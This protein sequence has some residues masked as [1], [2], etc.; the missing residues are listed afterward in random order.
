MSALDEYEQLERD[1]KTPKRLVDHSLA[2]SKLS[3]IGDVNGAASER[4]EAFCREKQITIGALAELG[5]R[6][7]IDSHGGVELAWGYEHRGAITAVK[8]RLVGDRRSVRTLA[9]ST[10]LQ[11]LVIGDRS[12]LDWFVGEGETDSCR[13]FELVGDVAAILC[14]PSGAL[15]FKREWAEAIPRGATVHLCH[16]ADTKGDQGAAKAAG[17][18]GGKTVRVRP[19]ADGLDWCS[20]TGGQAEF[21]ALVQA[22]R[23]VQADTSKLLLDWQRLSE[24]EMRSIVFRE[25]P[26]L[27][28]DAFHL[29][30]G[31]KGTG[32]GTVLAEIASRVTRGELGPNR[33]VVWIGSEDSAAIDI[34]PRIVAAGGDPE[35][36]L[37][38]KHGWIQLPRDIDEIT[39]AAAELGDVGMI[40]IDPVGNHIAGKNSNAET[41]IRD[42]ISRLNQIADEQQTMV[43]G[44]RHL[45]EKEC[46]RGVLAAILGSSAWVQTPRAVL[47]VVRDDEDTQISHVQCVAGNRLPAGTAGR[48]FRIDGVLLPGLENEV[49]RAVWL[50]ES[51]KDVETMFAGNA[52]PASK[53]ETARELILGILEDEGEQE[54]DAFDA[55]VAAATSLSAKTIRNQ[56]GELGKAGLVGSRPELDDYGHPARWFVY[57]TGAPR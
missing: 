54:S 21:V 47:A 30:C 31:R 18:L 7:N 25:K 33:N 51:T 17:V 43:F 3:P 20:W 46:G 11:P 19:P 53:S 39:R 14:L 49:T 27:Q 52:E 9:P 8:F 22:A 12:S 36:I 5:T 6:V 16:D 28:A 1:Q 44:V 4:I 32:K 29:V 42:A 2:W 50:G 57:R 45:T 40:S 38:V 10:Y 15:T 55:R 48:M 24:V 13:L 41:D 35:R 23:S 26:L 37:V 34:K 56:R